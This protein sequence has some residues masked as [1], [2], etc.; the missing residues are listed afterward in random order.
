MRVLAISGS[1]RQGS[2]NAALL[3]AAAECMP[4]VEFVVWRGLADL[5]AYDQDVDSPAPPAVAGLRREIGSADAVLIA[6]P[7]YNGSIPGALKNALDWM[8]RPFPANVLRKKRVAVVSASV[9]LFGAIG[10]QTELR[11]VLKVIGA[12]VL[13]AGLSVPSAHTA[14]TETGRLRDPEFAGALCE[15]V[16]DLLE[17]TMERAA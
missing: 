1:V 17:L 10:A 9:G 2:Y 12:D 6:T 11:K 3:R 15:I 4:A 14:F 5:P 7:E 8:S 13:E 16:R